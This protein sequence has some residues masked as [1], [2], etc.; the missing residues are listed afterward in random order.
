MI[1]KEMTATLINSL[2]ALD[3]IVERN[4]LSTSYYLLL[5]KHILKSV[6]A[7]PHQA[8]ASFLPANF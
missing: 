3:K 6:H 7:M 2:D 4:K 8:T 1:D 5:N